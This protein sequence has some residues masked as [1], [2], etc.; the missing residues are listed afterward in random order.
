QL[1]YRKD[2]P[3]RCLGFALL[4]F[5]ILA[6]APSPAA[7]DYTYGPDSSPQ[8][9]V[10]QGKVTGPIK[11]ESKIFDGTM[12]EYWVYVPAQYKP[13][14]PACVMVFQDG[15]GYVDAKGAFRVPIVFDNLIHKK[16]MPVT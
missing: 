14:E 15:K 8:A 12:R 5:A 9:G 11:W 4:A 1:A 13:D 6:A 2:P 3:M 7:D 16:E 10:P